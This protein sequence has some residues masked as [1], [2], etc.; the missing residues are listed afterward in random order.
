MPQQHR[1]DN[2]AAKRQPARLTSKLDTSLI[3]YALAATAAGVSVLATAEPAEARILAKSVNIEIPL[4]GGVIEFDVNQDGVPDF[5]LSARIYEFAGVAPTGNFSSS[6]RVIP[7]QAGNAVW[8]VSSH[9]DGCAAAVRGGLSI[10]NARPFE[11]EPLIMVE[12]AGSYTRGR[13]SHCPWHGAHPPYL[14]LK[15]LIDGQMHYGW[16]R[17]MVAERSAVLTGFAYETVANTAIT[18]GKT[19]ES[20]DADIQAMDNSPSPAGLQTL[21]GLALGSSE[22]A[23]KR[24]ED[25]PGE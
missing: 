7:A 14:G 19:K 1:E 23:W 15:F 25:E 3:A 13:S 12:A 9:K 11:P 24:P 4:N 16:A 8:A 22:M 17:V 18:A 21:G 20:S 10:D 6:L 5:G 2:R